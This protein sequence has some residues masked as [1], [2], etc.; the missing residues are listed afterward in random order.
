MYI[1]MTNKQRWFEWSSYRRWHCSS[2]FHFNC[3][4]YFGCGRMDYKE[5]GTVISFGNNVGEQSASS[6]LSQCSL[7]FQKRTF[8]QQKQINKNNDWFDFLFDSFNSNNWSSKKID[9]FSYNWYSWVLFVF[10]FVV[11]LKKNLKFLFFLLYV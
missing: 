11:D 10:L 1:S 9:Y 6:R 2:C 8:S 5:T 7:K 3:C 4:C